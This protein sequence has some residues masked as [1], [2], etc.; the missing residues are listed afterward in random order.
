MSAELIMSGESSI[1]EFR[2]QFLQNE[3]FFIKEATFT[4]RFPLSWKKH[5]DGQ[6]QKLIEFYILPCVLSSIIREIKA[7]MEKSLSYL[8]WF[9][10][11]I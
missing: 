8:S 10:K 7:L 3:Y 2:K 9:K 6:I 11:M 5:I 1:S 4:P